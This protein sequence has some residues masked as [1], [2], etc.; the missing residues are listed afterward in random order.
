MNFPINL[1]AFHFALA[2][3]HFMP[4]FSICFPSG[5]NDTRS[6]ISYKSYSPPWTSPSPTI[7]YSLIMVINPLFCRLIWFH[8][9]NL[10]PTDK[11][12][13][14]LQHFP[15]PSAISWWA[16]FIFYGKTEVIREENALT[17]Y[18]CIHDPRQKNDL[19]SITDW[20][21]QTPSSL[22]SFSYLILPVLTNFL[23]LL[24]HFNQL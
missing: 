14:S 9:F 7:V 15:F 23:F 11:K 8:F 13:F 20:S 3:S 24:D 21:L 22:F 16:F 4:S 10:T 17:L 5:K 12:K 19:Y 1:H 18:Y 2:L 6:D